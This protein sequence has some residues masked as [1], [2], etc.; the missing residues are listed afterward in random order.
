MAEWLLPVLVVAAYIVLMGWVLPRLGV[1]TLMAN[2]RRG[3]MLIEDNGNEH[4]CS[5]HPEAR[6]KGPGA[7]P[8]RL[9]RQGS[10]S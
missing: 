5:T 9:N 1:P 2:A 10:A 3:S 6:C 8:K 7:Y 4:A